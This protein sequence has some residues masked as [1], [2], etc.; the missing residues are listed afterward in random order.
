M[1]NTLPWVWELVRQKGDKAW[2]RTLM[3]EKW[4]N[5][6]SSEREGRHGFWEGENSNGE[7]HRTIA[8]GILVCP[9]PA[10][11]FQNLQD[12]EL[13]LFIHREEIKEE[14]G[15]STCVPTSLHHL[16]SR[17]VLL[18]RDSRVW[19]SALFLDSPN[20]LLKSP[21]QSSSLTYARTFLI[22]WRSQGDQAGPSLTAVCWCAG[23]G[24]ELA[25]ISGESQLLNPREPKFSHGGGIYTTGITKYHNA[26]PPP[27][28]A[29]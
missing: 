18:S 20:F 15:A 2:L 26:S 9:L 4:G 13:I 21:W 23:S 6:G 29:R 1:R 24:L 12:P 28:R 7:F 5:Q 16:E 8:S 22:P 17:W 14:E 25:C 19:M 27:Q 10:L 11:E 3:D